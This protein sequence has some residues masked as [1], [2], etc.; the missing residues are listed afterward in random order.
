MSLSYLLPYILLYRL[1]CYDR[2]FNFGSDCHQGMQVDAFSMDLPAATL[3]KDVH[4]DSE[5]CVSKIILM[6]FIDTHFFFRCP[7]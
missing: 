2:N 4:A 5:V 6:H 3:Y 1:E 7:K